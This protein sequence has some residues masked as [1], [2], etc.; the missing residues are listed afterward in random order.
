MHRGTRSLRVKRFLELFAIDIRTLALLR[1]SVGALTIVDVLLRARDLTAHYT[2][3]GVLPRAVALSGGIPHLGPSFHF[4]SGDVEVQALLFAMH[5]LAGFCLL[6]GYRTRLATI[7]VWTF[8]VSLAA[9]NPFVLN[10]GDR[11]LRLVL[12]WAMF[13][14]W[15]ERCSLDRHLG[16]NAGEPPRS[17]VSFAGAALLM[18]GF[19]VYFVT[20]YLKAGGNTWWDGTAVYYALSLDHFARPLGERLLHYPGLLRLLTHSVLLLEIGGP[21]LLFSPRWTDGCRL[22]VIGALIAFQTGLA[23]TMSLG[24]FPWASTVLILAYLPGSCW[25]WIARLERQPASP[26]TAPARSGLQHA[27][28]SF[29]ERYVAAFFFLF[30]I[31]LNARELAPLPGRIPGEAWLESTA[32]LDQKWGMFV[33]PGDAG[34]WAAVAGR[35]ADGRW[36]D[37]LRDG[38]AL[39]LSRPEFPLGIYPNRRWA[40][41]FEAV[42]RHANVAE[43][44][45]PSMTS[46]FCRRWNEQHP[47]NA[48]RESAIYAMSERTL[49][50]GSHPAPTRQLLQDRP[51]PD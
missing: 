49:L 18:Q 12:F 5:V 32:F 33:T 14:P 6:V 13:L 34:L 4:L 28:A 46:Y 15:G 27:I 36:I 11:I 31:L 43:R 20:G 29:A 24:L 44:L 41:L 19:F 22:L 9:R 51:C 30:L 47:R 25:D 10:G 42:S 8:T 45:T 50:D 23:T 26:A 3:R 21:L 48:I 39:D 17:I 37:L 35:S 7:L 40:T 2:D 16:R 1:V 38:R